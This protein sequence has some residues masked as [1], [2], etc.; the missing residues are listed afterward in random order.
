MQ[1][2]HKKILKRCQKNVR[3]PLILMKTNAME[4][5]YFHFSITCIYWLLFRFH[6]SGFCQ[7]TV[8]W[9]RFEIDLRMPGVIQG[10][11]QVLSCRLVGI[12]SGTSEPPEDPSFCCQ[13]GQSKYQGSYHD[14]KTFPSLYQESPIIKFL[15]NM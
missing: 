5:L 15:K 6:I 2:S 7:F 1:A 9:S 13:K 3:L 11:T 14:L 10:L 8:K 12:F 4:S